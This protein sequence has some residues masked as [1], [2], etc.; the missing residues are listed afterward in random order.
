MR[1]LLAIL[2]G[3]FGL[4]AVLG[5]GTLRD[6]GR[7]HDMGANSCRMQAVEVICQRLAVRPRLSAREMGS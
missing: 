3:C 5:H 2:R 1:W 4:L 7:C 6:G